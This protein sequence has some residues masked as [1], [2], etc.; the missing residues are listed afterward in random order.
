[1]LTIGDVLRDRHTVDAVARGYPLSE[2]T[3]AA[4]ADSTYWK[5]LS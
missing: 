5:P 2:E 3:I 1:M 4:Y